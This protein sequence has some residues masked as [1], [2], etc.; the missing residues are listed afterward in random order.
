[1]A[2]CCEHFFQHTLPSLCP[3][4]TMFPAPVSAH[5]IH[6]S[7][8]EGLLAL[9]FT[10]LRSHY[11]VLV[12]K[13]GK[14]TQLRA[15]NAILKTTMCSCDQARM[16]RKRC[17]K[18][19]QGCIGESKSLLLLLQTLQERSNLFRLLVDLYLFSERGRADDFRIGMAPS[20]R[21]KFVLAPYLNYLVWRQ[22]NLGVALRNFRSS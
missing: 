17:S 14:A 2:E 5:L 20:S 3:F 13:E 10:C 21:A 1:M 6:S 11:F 9:V 12:C 19:D 8:M 7:H 22:G 18:S 16:M 4:L 15:C